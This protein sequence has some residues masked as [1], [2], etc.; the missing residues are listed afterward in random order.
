[1]TLIKVTDGDRTSWV[2]PD[3]VL[4][5]STGFYAAGVKPDKIGK[6]WTRIWVGGGDTDYFEFALEVEAV[7]KL[8]TGDTDLPF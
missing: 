1:M 6:P 4:A 7:V 3:K 2:N 8:L 5:V